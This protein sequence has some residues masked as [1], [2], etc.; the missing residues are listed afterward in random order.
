MR[1]A[2]AAE[3]HLQAPA[4]TPQQQQQQQQQLY[5]GRWRSNN[6]NRTILLSCT[7]FVLCMSTEPKH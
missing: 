5:N 1:I 6:G 7:L 2:S 4:V 3:N